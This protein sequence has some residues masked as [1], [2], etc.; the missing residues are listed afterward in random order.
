MHQS[1]NNDDDENTDAV[2]NDD[3]D[4]NNNDNYDDNNNGN[5][6]NDVNDGDAGLLKN[7]QELGTRVV[8]VKKGNNTSTSVS[9][10]CFNIVS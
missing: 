7:V 10:K 5:A 2:D 9:T 6:I 8:K 3:D 1:N 4:D